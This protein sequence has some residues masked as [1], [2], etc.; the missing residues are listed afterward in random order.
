MD[1]QVDFQ[2]VLDALLNK[3]AP[4][5]PTLLYELSSI[6]PDEINSLTAVWPEIML[7]RRRALLEDLESLTERDNLLD[8]DD[9][10][11]IALQDPDAQICI[12]AMRLLWQAEDKHLVPQLI[13][14]LKTHSEESVR[15]AAAL[16]LGPYVYLG[17]I[18]KLPAKLLHEIEEELLHAARQDPSE[19]VRQR[20]LESLGYS[21]RPEVPTILQAAY[22][23]EEIAW[24]E[25]AL[26]AMGHSADDKWEP[27]VIKKLDHPDLSVQ[28]AAVHAAGE[29]M[30]DRA[31]GH[32]LDMIEE[33]IFDE[34]LHTEVVWA[35]SQIG[36]E[37]VRTAF[38]TLIEMTKDP[39]ETDL[40]EDALDN[41]SFSEDEILFDLMDIDPENQDDDDYD[42]DFD[43]DEFDF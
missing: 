25:S 7:E 22:D 26:S 8:F 10:G 15:T 37:G 39:D 3:D 36:G 12:N 16:A 34:D 27:A 11:R 9:I 4:F 13:D 20:A 19:L 1:N 42:I 18:D 23:S 41:L 32:L 14:F 30:L 2:F 21:G 17:E 31:R 5:P 33:E 38:E 6:Q 24:L 28:L 29:L 43:E 35:L 40:L